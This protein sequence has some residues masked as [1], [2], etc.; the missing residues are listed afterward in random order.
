MTHLNDLKSRTWVLD[1]PWTTPPLTLNKTL[2]YRRKAQVV[3]EVRKTAYTLAA[4]LNIPEMDRPTVHLV[5]LVTT[6]HKRD[7]DNIVPTLKALCD[8]LVDAQVAEDDTPEFMHKAMPLIHYAKGHH[9]APGMYLVIWDE[10]GQT[11]AE[12]RALAELAA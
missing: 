5:W 2:H 7:S 1:L 6:R 12:L 4:S 10:S 11:A 3:R 9:K 8:G